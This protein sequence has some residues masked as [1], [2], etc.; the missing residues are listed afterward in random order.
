MGVYIQRKI[1]N[2]LGVLFMN[3]RFCQLFFVLFCTIGSVVIGAETGANINGSAK[4][5]VPET[6]PMT[7]NP[8]GPMEPSVSQPEQTEN[9]QFDKFY[10]EFFRMML[11]LGLV[12]GL[13]MFITW[14]L[15]RMIN[16]RMQQINSSS[17][18]QVLEKRP[19]SQKTMLYILEVNGRKLVI[20]ESNNG[21][22]SLTEFSRS[23]N[24]EK[25]LDQER[26]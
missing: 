5:I 12:V 26:V 22:S 15:K 3:K 10:S 11:M 6:I 18:I 20:A 7:Y 24:F 23:P 14:L 9:E 13:L 4:E 17:V 19:L 21:V 25:I 1:F 16:N 8:G 2:I